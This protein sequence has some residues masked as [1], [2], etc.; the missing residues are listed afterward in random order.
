MLKPSALRARHRNAPRPA[1]KVADSFLK[2]LRGRPCFLDGKGGCGWADI[3]RKSYI[4]AAHVDCAGGKGVGSKVSDQFAIPLCQRHHDEQH[5]KIGSFKS[6]GGWATFQI[7]YGFNAVDV[8]GD[9]WHLWPDRRK[10]ESTEGTGE[11]NNLSG[12]YNG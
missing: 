10:W 6:R 11:A 4:E 3:P 9:Y 5:G 1:W 7:K 2:W 8:A 12:R